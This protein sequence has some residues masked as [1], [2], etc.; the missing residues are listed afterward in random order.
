M[1]MYITITIL[2]IITYYMY[3][4]YYIPTQKYDV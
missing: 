3:H 4:Y 2:G 1:K